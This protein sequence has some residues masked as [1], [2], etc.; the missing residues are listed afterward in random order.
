MR[1][2]QTLIVFSSHINTFDY[3]DCNSAK[4]V[5]SNLEITDTLEALLEAKLLNVPETRVY[6]FLSSSVSRTDANLGYILLP[7]EIAFVFNA[8]Q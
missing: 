1:K 6:S 2:Y 4:S 7:S 3:T 5:I 8:E